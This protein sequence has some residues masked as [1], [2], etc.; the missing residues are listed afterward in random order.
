MTLLRAGKYYVEC[1]IR[2]DEDRLYFFFPYNE[3][4]MAEIKSLQ[5][6]HYHG[7]DPIPRKVWSAPITPRNTWALNYLAKDLPNPYEKYKGDP[8]LVS[9]GR[10]IWDHQKTMTRALI[11]TRRAVWAADPRVGKTL[12]AITAI[13]HLKI[14]SVWWI[15]PRSAIAGVTKEFRKWQPNF[16]YELMTYNALVK[17]VHSWS[18]DAPLCVVFDE[19]HALKNQDSQRSQAAR[20]L[21]TSMLD[22][23]ED[24]TILAMSGSPNPK[25]PV[26]WWSICEVV[27]PGY[28]KEGHPTEFQK[29]LAL[30]IDGESITGGWYP[31]LITFW[32]NSKKCGVCGLLACDPLDKHYKAHKYIESINEVQRLHERLKG[33]VTVIKKEEC[34][35]LPPIETIIITEKEDSRLKPKENVLRAMNTI[36]KV[37]PSVAVALTLCRELS[38][39]FQYK[40]VPDG[41]KKCPE[42]AGGGEAWTH[43]DGERT[44][45]TCFKCN[46]T[47]VVPKFKR[48]AEQVYTP[49]DDLL[50]E[51]LEEHE[52]IGRLI[53]YA[54]FTASVDRCV[55]ICINKGWSVIRVDGRGWK[56]FGK[57]SFSNDADALDGF[58]NLDLEKIV[59]VG[60][61]DAGAEGI[62][63]AASPTIFYY[64]NTFKFDK[65]K[66]SSERINDSNQK[67]DCG[68]LIEIFYLP[69]DK[70]VYD[71]LINK[72]ELENM[73]MTGADNE[74]T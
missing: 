46:G 5:G 11:H 58:E 28:I 1:D 33:L 13:E 68:R 3:A 53:V 57:Y 48:I 8:E 67:A 72:R 38:D 39:G 26:D 2:K 30:V 22:E 25:S 43:I 7:Y 23:H 62:S 73:T 18:G 59:F 19:C 31:D 12:A 29:R 45:T 20:H 52:E 6:R 56:Y 49:K 37:A 27:C 65:K 51:C 74:Q 47:L 42:C 70:D 55:N 64:S 40:E 54:G 32:D 24:P 50:T 66:Q 9:L 16:K 17:K 69:T 63:L 36:K 71:N 14:P 10:E 44:F 60:H 61:P 4:L 41:D 34:M 35:Q 15:G 21:V